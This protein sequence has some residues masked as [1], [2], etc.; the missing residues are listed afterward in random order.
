SWVIFQVGILHDNQLSCRSRK[1]APERSSLALVF[2]LQNDGIDP[3][4]WFLC[5]Q[6]SGAISRAIVDDD[7]LDILDRSGPDGIDD[8][9]DRRAL[10]ITGNNNGQLHGSVGLAG[11]DPI[12]LRSRSARLD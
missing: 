7:D 6:F 5:E 10:I 3:V 8:R 9:L 12:R 1:P 11:F 4:G 2:V